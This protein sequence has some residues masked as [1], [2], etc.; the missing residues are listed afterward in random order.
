[1]FRF[2]NLELAAIAVSLD[3]DNETRQNRRFWIHQSLKLRKKE[4]EFF[5]LYPQLISDEEKF[6]KYF[7]MSQTQ[8][9]KILMKIKN[10]IRKRNTKYREA[11]TPIEKLAVCLR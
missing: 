7:R 4:G 5:T 3:E 11:I 1:M 10:S 6:Y 2:S 8:F 9:Q